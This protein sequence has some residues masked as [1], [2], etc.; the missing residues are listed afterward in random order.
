M[1]FN[2]LLLIIYIAYLVI[3]SII[4]I[5][6]YSA[7]KKKATKGNE[8]RIKEKVL[9]SISVIGGAIGSFIGRKIAHH[10]TDKGY[11][12][13]VIYTSLFSQLVVLL[14]LVLLAL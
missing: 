5:I 3:A 12:S 9:L 13:L 2:L 8:M 11:F 4:A 1:K 7:D 10:K 14:V 6:L